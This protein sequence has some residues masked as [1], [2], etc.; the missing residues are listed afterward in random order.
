MRLHQPPSFFTPTRDNQLL[1]LANTGAAS[2]EPLADK[3][4]PNSGFVSSSQAA[5]DLRW[6]DWP[7]FQ[8][9]L[10]DKISFFPELTDEATINT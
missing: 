8:A 4:A 3:N 9:C 6:T 7:K 10:E 1:L 2:S 5:P